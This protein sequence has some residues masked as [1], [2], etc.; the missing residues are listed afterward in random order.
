MVPCPSSPSPAELRSAILPLPQASPLFLPAP[1]LM[2]TNYSST[3]F[4]KALVAF[5]LCV[6]GVLPVC[7]F[8]HHDLVPLRSQKTVFDTLELELQQMVESLRVG[9]GNQTGI[10]LKG[11]QVLLTTKPS[12]SVLPFPSFLPS[13]FLL[14]QGPTM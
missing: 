12:L 9:A 11:S 13:L 1:K 5:I 8:V 2:R 14:R 10:F 4:F 3:S 6:V 7:M